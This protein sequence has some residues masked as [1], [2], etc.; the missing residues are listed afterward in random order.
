MKLNHKTKTLMVSVLIMM[1]VLVAMV[2]VMLLKAKESGGIDAGEAVI[3]GIIIAMAVFSVLSVLIFRR[4]RERHG[5]EMDGSFRNTLEDIMAVIGTS[6]ISAVEKRQIRED[7]MDLFSEASVDGRTVL[8]LIG[9]NPDQFA[10]DIIEA[11]GARN[12][13]WTYLLSGVQFFMFYLLFIQ[14]YTYAQHVDE[15]HGFF[16]VPLDISTIILFAAVSLIAIP[17][18]MWIKHT[19][20]RKSSP[21]MIAIGFVLIIAA[22][23]G[24]VIGV[25]A[26]ADKGVTGWGWLQDVLN[27]EVV[28]FNNIWTWAAV[29]IVFGLSLFFKRRIRKHALNRILEK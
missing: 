20:I 26:L 3:A 22:V 8:D 28:L 13:I 2:G 27:K 17:L 6:N 4:F 23:F 15:M 14:L 10:A 1:G 24:L 29:I 11:H 9:E 18:M 7:L 25:Y 19:G 5:P 12:N 16:A 21:Y